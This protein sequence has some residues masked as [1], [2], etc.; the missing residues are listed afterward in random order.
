MKD[1]VASLLRDPNRSRGSQC[2]SHPQSLLGLKANVIICDTWRRL[3]PPVPERGRWYGSDIGSEMWM[4]MQ[5]PST[6]FCSE[7]AVLVR[8]GSMPI[9]RLCGCGTSGGAS[10]RDWTTVPAADGI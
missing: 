2:L 5:C 9:C 6:L 7:C 8:E 3:R 1:S 10:P 4:C